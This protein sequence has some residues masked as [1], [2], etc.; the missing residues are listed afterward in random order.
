[1]SCV[2]FCIVFVGHMD[3]DKILTLERFGRKVKFEKSNNSFKFQNFIIFS[4]RFSCKSGVFFQFYH[5]KIIFYATNSWHI[6]SG[7]THSISKVLMPLI[8]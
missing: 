8:N 7:T 2:K 6:S 4:L 3:S 5:P 1:M